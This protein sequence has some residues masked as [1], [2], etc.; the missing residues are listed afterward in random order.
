MV[1]G[2]KRNWVSGSPPTRR[3]AERRSGRLYGMDEE[4]QVS[5]MQTAATLDTNINGSALI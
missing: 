1:I 4:Q 3:I 2:G 5:M